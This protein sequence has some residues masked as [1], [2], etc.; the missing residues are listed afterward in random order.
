MAKEASGADGAQHKSVATMIREAIEANGYKDVKEC[1][2]SI[3]VPYDL[4]NKVVG[5]HIPKDQQLLEYARKLNID[6]RELILAAYREKAPDE[7]KRYFNSVL[8]LE[9]HND[10]VREVL[11]LMDTFNGDQLEELVRM[12]R[13]INGSPREHC[14]KAAALLE[15]YQQLEPEMMEH[16]ESLV[17]LAL[18][19]EGLSGLQAFRDSVEL[20]NNGRPGR[21]GRAN[22]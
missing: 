15:L 22:A 12:A 2:R 1:A 21:R 8:L 11:E 9:H 7:M 20:H 18:R 5:G 17:L 6:A 13:I 3:K 14:R 10:R 16:F 19:N 4:F